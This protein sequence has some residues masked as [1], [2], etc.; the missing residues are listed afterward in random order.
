MSA[1]KRRR[2]T[3]VVIV[4]GCQVLAVLFGAIRCRNAELLTL[5]NDLSTTLTSQRALSR[6]QLRLPGQR[7]EIF[8]RSPLGLG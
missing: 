5:S 4:T 6:L 1:E 8:S 3:K 7:V 2:G